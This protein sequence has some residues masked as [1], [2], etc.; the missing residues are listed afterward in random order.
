MTDII[1]LIAMS[2][3]RLRVV[4]DRATWIALSMA[5]AG[6]WG[7]DRRP[8]AVLAQNRPVMHSVTPAIP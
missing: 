8:L 3:A 2:A 5:V 6:S 1:T 7:L 4:L